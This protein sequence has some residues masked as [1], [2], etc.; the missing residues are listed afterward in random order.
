MTKGEGLNTISPAVFNKSRNFCVF[1]LENIHVKI[2]NNPKNAQKA[3]RDQK[4]T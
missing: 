3:K 2:E 1:V 4:R